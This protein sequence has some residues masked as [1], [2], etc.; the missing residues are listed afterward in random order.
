MFSRLMGLSR[1]WRCS[2]HTRLRLVFANLLSVHVEVSACRRQDLRKLIVDER[3]L[4]REL[5][6]VLGEDSVNS[7]SYIFRDR[8]PG[9]GVEL[10][11]PLALALGD[12]HRGRDLALAH[13]RQC[14]AI[15]VDMPGPKRSRGFFGRIPCVADKDVKKAMAGEN[16]DPIETLL[17]KAFVESPQSDDDQ[18]LSAEEIKAYREGRL[19]PSEQE[20]IDAHLAVCAMCR[21]LVLASAETIDGPQRRWAQSQLGS[22]RRPARWSRAAM[23]GGSLAAA[24]L[25]V[26]FAAAMPGYLFDAEPLTYRLDRPQGW[27]QIVRGGEDSTDKRFK[28]APDGVLVLRFAPLD[29]AAEMPRRAV[30]V[31]L[32][33]PS[34]WR[35]L[36]ARIESS[37]GVFRVSIH[38]REALGERYGQKRLAIVLFDSADSAAQWPRSQTPSPETL[39]YWDK[40][41][42]LGWQLRFDFGT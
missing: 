17:K 10:F 30:R 40:P 1:A 3:Q 21:G 27:T 34:G 13:I 35:M 26:V 7:L 28:L 9:S 6:R 41:S 19:T 39:L 16:E 25:L 24:A 22:V 42:S 11:E 37:N 4:S 32:D 38:A 8:N 5:V 33:E 12:V 29:D 18:H 23:A 14:M 36:P 15:D 20:R 2:S 31:F